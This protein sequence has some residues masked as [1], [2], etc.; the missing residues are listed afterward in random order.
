MK[1]LRPT[2]L[3]LNQSPSKHAYSKCGTK[4]R[5]PQFRGCEVITLQH[6]AIVDTALRHDSEQVLSHYAVREDSS[7]LKDFIVS[8]SHSVYLIITTDQRD[9]VIQSSLDGAKVHV[10]LD[11]PRHTLLRL[12]LLCKPCVNQLTPAC[13]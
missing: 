5:M 4:L 1:S 6:L 12:S 2:K 9:K 7:E 11:I 13:I 3:T 10:A 8:Y